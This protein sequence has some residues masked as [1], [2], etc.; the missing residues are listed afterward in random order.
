MRCRS[1]WWAGVAF[2][3]LALIAGWIPQGHQA[4]PARGA[5]FQGEG[6]LVRLR[7]YPAPVH[8][9]VFTY[10]CAASGDPSHLASGS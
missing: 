10:R 2:F 8:C 7:D 6:C 9:F 3:H 4:L 1:Q 5:V